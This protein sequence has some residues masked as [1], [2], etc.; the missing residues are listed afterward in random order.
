MQKEPQNPT[1]GGDYVMIDGVLFTEQDAKL[2]EAAMIAPTEP[3][4][5]EP[6]TAKKGR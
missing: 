5:A 4:K 3:A 6:D 2:R 1:Q